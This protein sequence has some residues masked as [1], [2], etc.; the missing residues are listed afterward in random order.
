MQSKISIRILLVLLITVLLW[1]SAFPAIRYSLMDYSVGHL[2]LIRFL[3]ASFL[4]ILIAFWQ[5]IRLPK[6]GDWPLLFLLGGIGFTVY[7][8]ALVNGERTV[9]SGTASIIVASSPILTSLMSVVFL[10]EKFHLLGWLGTGVGLLGVTVITFR[11]PLTF[12]LEPGALM[13]FLAAF[14]IS[15]YSVFQKKLHLNYSVLQI[16]VF[17]VVSG[18]CFLLIYGPGLAP[19][20]H[21]A[22][23]GAT[24]SAIYLGVFPT[25]IGFLGWNYALSKVSATL[26]ASFQY[27][28]PFFAVLIA[29]IWLAEIPGWLTFAG[30]ILT[31][32]GVAIVNAWGKQAYSPSS[33]ST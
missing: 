9:L 20:I 16:T 2:I 11:A 21:S 26:A 23:L 27:L 5:R 8:I 3:S 33:S 29:W 13:I 32:A 1:A 31:I 24:L 4:L 7:N 15:F 6:M 14:S 22:P 17:T 25:V 10:K 19:A 30:G 18:T 28:T 12:Q